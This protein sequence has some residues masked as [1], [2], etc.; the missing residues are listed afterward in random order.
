MTPRHLIIYCDESADK[1]PFYSHFYGGVLLDASNRQRIERAL[2]DTCWSQNLH[3]E[4]K[5]TKVTAQYKN[6]YI[7]FLDKFFTFIASGELKVR[8]MFTQNSNVPIGLEEHQI[9]NEYFLLY[10]QLVKHAFGL[11]YCGAPD[12]STNVSLFLDD[13]PS[14][15][16]RFESFRAYVE[17]LSVYPN[18]LS[19]RVMFSRENITSVNSKHHIILQGLDIILGSIQFRLN[20]MHLAKPPGQRLRS[21]RTRAKEEVYKFINTKI[22]SIYPGFNVGVSTAVRDDF[23][24][25]WH[26]AYRHWLFLPTEY[27]RVEGM[28]KRARGA[29]RATSP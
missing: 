29:P 9:A 27:R 23:A 15:P 3:A 12:V 8:I 16:A 13:I 14:N 10:Y 18:F 21:N 26:H 6:K 2:I 19:Q 11:M 20:N 1:G 25:R 28:G 17:S 7:A 5:W 4:L 22:R 24:N